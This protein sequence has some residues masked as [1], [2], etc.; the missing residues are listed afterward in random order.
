M[1]S[2]CVLT[3]L[4]WDS[5]GTPQSNTPRIWVLVANIWW[6][7]SS[8]INSKRWRHNIRNIIASLIVLHKRAEISHAPT[9]SPFEGT[10]LK[11]RG[12]SN[13]MKIDST[14]KLHIWTTIISYLISL[15]QKGLA[16]LLCQS[17]RRYG[18]T[19]QNHSARPVHEHLDVRRIE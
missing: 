8:S 13:I 19:V 11:M 1:A 2:C 4:L 16:S 14:M 12:L 10:Q 7:Y 18:C 5:V 3:L 6:P 17:H 9:L 15:A